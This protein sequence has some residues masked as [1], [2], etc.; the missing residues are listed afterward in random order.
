M[1]VWISHLG[2]E[3]AGFD[4]G[5]DWVLWAAPM[6]DWTGAAHVALSSLSVLGLQK[7]LQFHRT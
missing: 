6:G 5:I 7:P 2:F 4:A 1:S 3:R